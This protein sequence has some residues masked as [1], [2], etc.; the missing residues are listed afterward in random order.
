MPVDARGHAIEDATD[1]Y[2]CVLPFDV[3]PQALSPQ[4][5]YVFTANNDPGNIDTD[6]DHSNDAYYIGGP[7]NSVRGATIRDRL[8]EQAANKTASIAG[9]AQVQGDNTSRTGERF[10]PH[11]LAALQN[12]RVLAEQ[13]DNGTPLNADDL[14]LAGLYTARAE[15]FAEVASRLGAWSL[16]A[17]SGVET[18]YAQPTDLDREDAVATMI[19]NAWL[20]RF[21]AGVWGDEPVAGLF[22]YNASYGRLTAIDAFL[23]VRGTGDGIAS[24]DAE[25]GESVFFDVVGTPEKERADEVMLTALNDALDFLGAPQ[26]APGVGGF[27]T[28]DMSQWLWGLRH[29]VVF[30][31][32]LGGFLGDD[33][34]FAVFTNQFAIGTNRVPLAENIPQGDPRRGLKFFPRGADNW[35][36]DAGHPGLSGTQ[37]TYRNGP[38][39]RMVIALKDGRVTGQNI[40]PGGQSALTD[41]PFF[42]D[43]VKLWLANEAVPLRFHVDQVV[44]GAT[45]REVFEPAAR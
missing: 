8:A 26:D 9:M 34:T 24:H 4:S 35:A 14:R 43:Q 3:L 5:G 11:L 18:F 41:S 39:M 36:V 38:V 2:A 31:S 13:A 23:K 42:D 28:E 29:M 7:W 1:P 45:G 15:A 17:Q 21:S 20:P 40:I 10:V 25:T 22:P 44:E 12:A 27:G 32:L 30:E 37:F 33:P 16:K 19:F 6:A